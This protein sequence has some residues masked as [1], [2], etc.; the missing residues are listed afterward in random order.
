MTQQSF[1]KVADKIHESRIELANSLG[2][3]MEE[4]A[5][6]NAPWAD[7]T[8]DAREGLHTIVVNDAV[9]SAI[10]LGHGK[11]IYYGFFLETY[12]YN[13]VSYAIIAPT[14]EHFAPQVM[15]MMRWPA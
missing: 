14:I 1:E 8:T 7:R 4:Y 11:N 10:W 9:T 2:Q 6:A 12:T 3:V 5:K 13:G 15:G